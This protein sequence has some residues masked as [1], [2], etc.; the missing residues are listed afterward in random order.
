[1]ELVFEVRDAAL[2]HAVFTEADSWDELRANATEAATL[3]FEDEPVQP[4]L[5]QLHCS[6][7]HYI[8]DE[9]IPLEAA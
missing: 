5:I 2:G 3:H 9:L 7:P 6:R 1:M 8:N 4:R